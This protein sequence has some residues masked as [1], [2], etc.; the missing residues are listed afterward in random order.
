[1]A[2]TL[3]PTNSLGIS[4]EPLRNTT[5]SFG[6]SSCQSFPFFTNVTVPSVNGIVTLSPPLFVDGVTL[7][8]PFCHCEIVGAAGFSSF[9]TTC[10]VTWFPAFP[11]LSTG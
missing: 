6:V 9:T 11:W 4:N 2:V 3:V 10:T 1:M 8:F 5:P 7:T